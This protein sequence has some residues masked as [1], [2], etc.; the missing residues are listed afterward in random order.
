VTRARLAALL[1][2]AAIGAAIWWELPPAR[3]SL[4][5]S[6]DALTVRGALH[7][8][9]RRSD[10]TGTPEDVAKAAASAGLDFVILTDH[11][12]ATRFTDAPRYVDGVLVLDGVE[13]STTGGHYI[14]LGMPRAPYRLAGEP[15]DVVE[16]VRR[17]GGFGIAAHPDSPKLELSWQDGQANADAL[18]WLNADSQW[19]DET[20]AALLR[21][22][23]SYWLRGPES[24]VSLF[25]RPVSAIGQWDALTRRR[26][27]VAVAG[28]D[29]HAR[30]SLGGGW[31]P[32][33][34]ERS[35]ALPSYAAAF[36][37]FA[38]RAMLPRPW[39][40]TAQSA[41]HDAGALLDALRGGRV[42]TVI[43]ALAGPARLEFSA[44]S[45]GGTTTMGGIVTDLG[46]VAF[47]AAL[48]PEVS[49]AAIVVVKDGHDFR[50][51]RASSVSFV[52][53]AGEGRATYR[54]E[55]RLEGAP[56]EPP[57]P[58]I[59]GNPIYVTRGEAPAVEVV[60]PRVVG[61]RM[62]DDGSGLVVWRIE[63]HAQ[64]QGRV[65]VD[66]TFHKRLR[67][68]WRLA[69]GPRVSQYAAM[70]TR[71]DGRALRVFN[72]LAFRASASRPMRLS[73]QLRLPDGRR[74]RRSV[75]VDETSREIV[76]PMSEMTSVAPGRRRMHLL[77]A[78]SL[79]FVV[80]TVNTSPGTAG[81]TWIDSIRWQQVT[82]E[83]RTT[84]D[85]LERRTQNGDLRN[86]GTGLGSP[87]P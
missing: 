67:F 38:L 5:L 74:W 33:G 3:R 43:D 2:V 49:G 19:R 57:V 77:R 28:H 82:N 36:Q 51:T 25:D 31:E 21:T 7:V 46:E 15:R 32:T 84:S 59:V 34:D 64:C 50:T 10:G 47:K 41:A 61:Q 78:E 86:A 55:V 58:W 27:V 4:T 17:L 30:M 80:D 9:T 56:G 23:L 1:V 16:D 29:A 60:P 71:L 26:A 35:L 75:F 13:I 48:T 54:V 40:R 81:E 20:R 72:Q 83:R 76:V 69:E 66:P 24:I 79:L 63:R 8:H 62:F 65:K 85:E 14:A 22:V 39:G 37:A 52:R 11:G 87:K 70:V 53:A 45:T 6:P 42:Y 73:V 18:E 12:D 44:V 68:S